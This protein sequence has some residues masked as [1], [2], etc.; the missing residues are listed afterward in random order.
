MSAHKNISKSKT[1]KG[2]TVSP[3]IEMAKVWKIVDSSDEM[4]VKPHSIDESDI[5][6]ELSR[7]N[8]AIKTSHEQLK[9]LYKMVER[10]LGAKEAGIFK[11]HM[12]ILDDPHFLTSVKDLI[13][14][15][16]KNIEHIINEVIKKFSLMFSMLDDNLMRERSADIRD[17][18]QR[19]LKNLLSDRQCVLEPNEKVIIVA[20]ELI[21]S[22]TVKSSDNILGFAVEH[23]EM[24]SHAS[25]LARSLNIPAIVGVEN[26]CS[27]AS[28]GDTIIIDGANSL[29][30]VNPLNKVIAE[31]KR[32]Q[33]EYS[34]IKDDLKLSSKLPSV[35]TDG[36]TI[37]LLANINK[38][39]DIE[40]AKQYNASGIGLF[41]TE[42]FFMSADKMPGEEEQYALYRK[43][44]QDAGGNEVTIRVLD[45]GAD[46]TL[47]YFAM[48]QECNPQ[49]GWRG[50]RILLSELAIF[51]T[52][53]RA[54][55][56]AS[57]YGRVKLLLPMISS[58][59]E[60]IDARDI[61][62]EA[63]F[64]LQSR[65]QLDINIEIGAMIEVPA[66]VFILDEISRHVDFLSIGTNDLIQYM[67]AVDRNNSRVA[68]FYEPLH[69]AVMS[70]IKMIADT[71]ARNKKDVVL[72]GELAGDTLFTMILMGLG[73][74][75]LSMNPT[76]I[77][78]VRKV[79]RSVPLSKCIEIAGDILKIPCM[80]ESKKYLKENVFPFLDH[81][82]GN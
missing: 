45:I 52:Q 10:R 18:G 2:V 24:M 76:A 29:V 62:E 25:I 66:A 32:V 37:K 4:R 68:N 43:V 11:A 3:G 50:I 9:A 54:I 23:G 13:K 48:P 59:S 61:I 8:R 19:V 28:T 81:T 53:I 47:S 38:V 74:K 6:K 71:A 79:I 77:P 70:V 41:R 78:G 56:R 72:C 22:I 73:V 63:K 57:S 55:L 1:L 64:E 42:F 33:I 82:I 17:V 14:S 65:M 30:I 34:V 75:K 20:K 21:P 7:F 5:E 16:K 15:E 46:K 44:I 12:L 51:K 36:E 49:L 60:I 80:H 35:T 27:E 26:I 58:V 67:L 40:L 39:S 69:P 31:Y